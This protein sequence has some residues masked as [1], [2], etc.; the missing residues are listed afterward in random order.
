MAVADSIHP[1]QPA[2]PY[3]G[4]ND[5]DPLT[6]GEL[7]I[8]LAIPRAAKSSP[9]STLFRLPLGPDPALGWIDV[10]C[11]EAHSI[12]SRLSATWETR[13][14]KLLQEQSG[15]ACK[16]VGPGTT[17]C[18][19][20]Q[21]SA[22]AL[23]HQ[24]AF[25]ALGC[26]VH[27]LSLMVGDDNVDSLLSQSGGKVA[28]CSGLDPKFLAERR[29]RFQGEILELPEEEQPHR[30]AQ[31]EKQG[32]GPPPPPWPAPRRPTP[33]LILQSSATTGIPKLLKYSLY[34]YTLGLAFNCQSYLALAHPS[35]PKAK[36]PYT[37]PR[38]TFS[39]PYWQSFYRTFFVHLLTATPLAFAH[40]PDV[41]KL[42]SE[43]FIT[44]AQ[45]LDVGATASYV[46]FVRDVV[47]WGTHTEFLQSL[48]TIGISG[49]PVDEAACEMFIKYNLRV[50]NLFGESELGRLLF[51]GRAPL[52]H[53]KP[54]ADVPPP[55]PVP[56]AAPEP[57][58]SRRVQLW[59]TIS[60]S[61]VLAHLH[62]K[63]GVPFNFEPFPGEGPYH[64]EPAINQGDIFRETYA[65]SSITGGN[66]LVY[67]HLG[68]TNDLI[69]VVTE[70]AEDISAAI[71]EAQLW[72]SIETRLKTSPW[73]LEAIQVFGDNCPCTSLVVQLAWS[74]HDRP[75]LEGKLGE[76]MWKEL[77]NGVDE[78]N[79]Q[80]ELGYRLKIHS[81]KRMLVI[82]PEGHAH[83][84]GAELLV[85]KN[86][87]RV[88]HKYSLQRWKNVRIFQ[89]WLDGLDY[90][91]P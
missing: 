45:G 69:R 15:G 55:I 27:Y 68:R 64:G 89:P 83:G 54:F 76:E 56:I 16:S 75:S 10:T 1:S 32:Q 53:L 60:T 90:S 14:S 39:P 62:A 58:G 78:T 79:E 31:I 4:P 13:L 74:G 33:M 36:N 81:G 44:W 86:G 23:F 7:S 61:P 5:D 29:A 85:G 26:T 57:D 43:H 3:T 22:H 6:E 88:T 52:R 11:A 91:E 21:P 40:I 18:M 41:L 46:R 49:T 30:L 73:R 47:S 50:T 17:I 48:F 51:A 35:N 63:G 28:L 84:P 38:L 71:V 2:G 24:L 12:I 9:N 70:D 42:T 82:S 77:C 20:V 80:L 59:Y 65:P 66:E 34:Y 8:L 87:L 37:H 19:L 72:S 25:W 67:I